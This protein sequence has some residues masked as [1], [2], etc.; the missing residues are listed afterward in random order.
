MFAKATPNGFEAI[1]VGET[2]DLSE[3]FDS[4][5]KAICIRQHG[6]THIAAVV[7]RGGAAARR[8]QGQDIKNFYNPACNG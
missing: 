3:G 4:H 6:A 2:Q 5:H 8:A 7:N 1:Y